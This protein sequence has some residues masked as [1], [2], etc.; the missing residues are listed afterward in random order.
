MEQEHLLSQ[1]HNIAT[2]GVA[3]GFGF[4]SNGQP[5]DHLCTYKPDWQQHYWENGLI[6][7]DPIISFGVRNLGAV[8]WSDVDKME[9]SDAVLQAR[10]FGMTN[11]I[12]LSVQVDGERAI[13]GLATEGRPSEVAIREARTILAALQASK[14][15]EPAIT[16]TP[17]QKDI[18]R[19]IAD[20]ASAADTAHELRIDVSTVNFHKREALKRNRAQAKNFTALLAQA[21]RTAA[22]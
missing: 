15:G 1:L 4:S 19:L 9:H 2:D 21:V 3:I 13:A 20:G 11:G 8:R 16:L 18:L 12:V 7:R 14:S 5:T 6:Y 22:I 17:R 10:E